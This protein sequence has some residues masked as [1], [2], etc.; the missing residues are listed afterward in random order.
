VFEFVDLKGE[1]VA[2]DTVGVAVAPP[3]QAQQFAM[4]PKGPTIAAWRYRK[5]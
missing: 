1:V 2:T 3:G 4:K 5:Q